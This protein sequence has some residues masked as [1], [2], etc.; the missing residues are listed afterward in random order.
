[1]RRVHALLE[2]I[3]AHRLYDHVVALGMV[4]H[5]GIDERAGEHDVG[6]GDDGV[7]GD[8]GCHRLSVDLKDQLFGSPKY[9]VIVK[10]RREIIEERGSPS[11]ASML[12]PGKSVRR[13][14][15]QADVIVAGVL[16]FG[17]I[18]LEI[19]LDCRPGRGVHPER[20][21]HSLYVGNLYRGFKEAVTVIRL[22]L[23]GAGGPFD[24]LIAAVGLG[25]KRL[26]SQA[27]A[28]RLHIAGPSAKTAV[29]R[30]QSP[31]RLELGGIGEIRREDWR[32]ASG[33]IALNG[34]AVGRR[35][36]PSFA[37]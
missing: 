14:L 21:V 6:R 16:D 23:N 27:A 7:V 15:L 25:S 20:V 12:H 11:H 18:N 8:S 17:D 30:H 34:G 9:A 19:V 33:A 5:T 2:S 36:R 32:L 24:A 26:Q 1:M 3:N 4:R 10:T 28:C 29:V 22:A 37:V 35:N 31:I 13:V